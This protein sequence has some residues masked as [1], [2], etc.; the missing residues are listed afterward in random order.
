MSIYHISGS[1]AMRSLSPK[2]APGNGE[3]DQQEAG[4]VSSHRARTDSIEISSEGQALAAQNAEASERLQEVL[5]R[6]REGAY[7]SPEM[8]EQVARSILESGDL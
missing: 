7:D 1:G 8:A 6:I 3:L 4:D 2:K 5:G